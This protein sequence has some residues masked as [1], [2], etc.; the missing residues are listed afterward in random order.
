MDQL[1]AGTGPGFAGRRVAQ[2]VPHAGGARRKDRQIG[3]ALALHLELAIG[4]R[5]ADFVVG[6]S[7]TRWRRF[8][9]LVCLDLLAAPPLVL[10]GRGGVMAVAIDDHETCLPLNNSS[11]P[12]KREPRVRTEL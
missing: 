12:P 2:M 8:A 3:A 1:V 10:A 9:G 11:F 6:N 5:L 7:R 4:D